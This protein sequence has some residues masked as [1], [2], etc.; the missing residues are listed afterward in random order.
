MLML[1]FENLFLDGSNNSFIRNSKAL[2]FTYLFYF[3]FLKKVGSELNVW[4]ELMT[5]RSRPQ[6]RGRVGRSP[7]WTIQVFHPSVL[8]LYKKLMFLCSILKDFAINTLFEKF[9]KKLLVGRKRKEGKEE[10]GRYGEKEDKARI[11]EF[12]SITFLSFLLFPLCS[13]NRQATT[14]PLP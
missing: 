3:S 9:L 13:R 5:P 8:N 14:Q 12:A 7:N 11:K 4:P 10:A 2:S 1:D 6:Q